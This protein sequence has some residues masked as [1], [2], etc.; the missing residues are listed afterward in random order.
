MRLTVK[1]WNVNGLRAAA[2][3]GFGEWLESCGADVV[4]LQETKAREEQLDDEI[5]A[6]KGWRTVFV[7]A[8]RPGY[9]G[10]A[11]YCR[12]EPDEVL[13]GLGAKKYDCEG[14]T[15]GLRYGDL[16]ILGAYFP[17][18]GNEHARVPYKLG[19][20]R[21]MLTR[22]KQLRDEGRD[23]IVAGDYNTAHQ[24]I[25]LARPKQNEKTTGFLPEER[26]WLD[27]YVKAGF[28]DTFRHAHPEREGAYSWWSFRSGA[29]QRNVGWRIDYHFL[30]EDA[31]GRI[32]DA[33][34]DA[35][36]EGSDHCPVG[37][38]LAGV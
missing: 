32:L 4:L 10:V 14:R 34:I 16:W 36:V 15:V 3:K 6:P 5:R 12:E 22:M 9:S 21:R 13:T 7:S 23:V 35:E 1:S 8:E 37:L 20:Y 24:P 18:G 19:F 29:R 33:T 25:D 30:N 17:N 27:K 31:A 2:R 28:V 38:V 26:V 11:A